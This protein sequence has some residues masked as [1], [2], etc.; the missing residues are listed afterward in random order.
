MLYTF[1]DAEAEDRHTTQCFELTAAVPSTTRDGGPAPTTAR[2]ADRVARA[3]PFEKDVWELYDMRTDFG[4]ATDS[5]PNT[6]QAQRTPDT[7]RPRSPQAQHLPADK[8]CWPT[9]R[10]SSRRQGQL[11]PRHRPASGGGDH[12]H[13]EPIVLHHR[14]GRRNP[15]GDAEASSVTLGG[16]TGGFASP[17][18]TTNRPSSTAGSVWRNTRSPPRNRCPRATARSAS[19]SPTTAAASAKAAPARCR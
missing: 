17:Y 18:S 13:Q 12:R 8:G 7:L 16:E 6:P 15:D 5:S 3:V 1:D 4:H 10:R 19:T 2:T 11:H 14:R 9:A